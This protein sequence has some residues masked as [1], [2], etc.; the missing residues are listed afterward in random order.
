M[1][2]TADIFFVTKN[3][4]FLHLF[5]TEKKAGEKPAKT[6]LELIADFYQRL[7]PF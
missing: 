1:K 4:R 5:M 3:I 2:N 7:L 6:Y